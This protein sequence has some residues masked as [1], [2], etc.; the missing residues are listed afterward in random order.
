MSEPVNAIV[1]FEGEGRGRGVC[2]RET[3]FWAETGEVQVFIRER[4]G[5]GDRLRL[6]T[7]VRYVTSRRSASDL[8]HWTCREHAGSLPPPARLPVVHRH[9][10]PSSG[11]HRQTT[12]DVLS[13]T[14][15][16]EI[17]IF[18]RQ[19]RPLTYRRLLTTWHAACLS[20]AIITWR[21]DITPVRGR[22]ELSFW[23][24][25]S[26]T[27]S[28]CAAA[29]HTAMASSLCTE[30]PSTAAVLTGIRMAAPRAKCAAVAPT[31]GCVF[32]FFSQNRFEYRLLATHKSVGLGRHVCS[33]FV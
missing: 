30:P 18:V 21:Y 10:C 14:S 19:T 12:T 22:A 9:R 29:Y 2:G 23:F 25:L 1:K 6:L 15:R 16:T 28:S 27:S 17:I 13:W 7:S 32:R 26:H 11:K 31:A 20:T 33:N 3:R 4:V 5:A 8:S 24:T